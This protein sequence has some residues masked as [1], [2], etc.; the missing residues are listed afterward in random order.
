MVMVVIK[1]QVASN[2]FY[3]WW[4]I[5]LTHVKLMG[6]GLEVNLPAIVSQT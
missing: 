2:Y 4:K 3:V 1:P 6:Y 5:A